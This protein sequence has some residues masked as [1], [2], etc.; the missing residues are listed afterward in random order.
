[1]RLILLA[2]ILLLGLTLANA[3]VMR[4]ESRDAAAHSYAPL[5]LGQHRM[6]HYE[7]DAFIWREIGAV[8][9]TAVLYGG[10]AAL[11]RRNA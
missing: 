1:M 4:Q 6:K 11:G 5:Q 9:F 8:A 2:V 10:V 7:W 3:F